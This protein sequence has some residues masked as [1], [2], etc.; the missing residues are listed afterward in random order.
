MYANGDALLQ[1]GVNDHFELILL[2]SDGSTTQMDAP[3]LE[4]TDA[5]TLCPAEPG[6]A[7]GTQPK[8]GIVYLFKFNL[9]RRTHELVAKIP[10]RG[11]PAD[12]GVD[13]VCSSDG[14]TLA[15]KFGKLF[16]VMTRPVGR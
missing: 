10:A 7:Y 14:K 6:C 1:R 12:S 4:Y 9:V 16:R 5:V 13:M 15:I 8:E 3:M 2:K 11:D